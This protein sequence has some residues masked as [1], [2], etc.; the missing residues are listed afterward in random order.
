MAMWSYGVRRAISLA[1]VHVVAG[2]MVDLGRQTGKYCVA[3]V[4]S[5]HANAEM[6]LAV[7][8]GPTSR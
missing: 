3:V 1:A 8:T 4:Q 7:T 2:A 6:R 5:V